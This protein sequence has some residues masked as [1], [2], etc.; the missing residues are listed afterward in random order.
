M[1][2]N[3]IK[4]ITILFLIHLIIYHTTPKQNILRTSGDNFC[5]DWVECID[6]IIVIIL[7][8]L[9]FTLPIFFILIIIVIIFLSSIY[10]LT[11]RNHA[12]RNFNFENNDAILITII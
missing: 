5:N 10:Y 11:F 12:T 3:Y 6:K 1:L 9:I 7:F 4:L 8:T 2:K